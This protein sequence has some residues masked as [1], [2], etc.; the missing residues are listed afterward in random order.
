MGVSSCIV[1]GNKRSSPNKVSMHRFSKKQE[2]RMQWLGSLSLTQLDITENSRVCSIH[3]HDGNPCNI[4]SWSVGPK[5]ATQPDVD[6]ERS[7]RAQKRQRTF[8]ICTPATSKTLCSNTESDQP[9]PA[10]IAT[11][12]KSLAERRGSQ[13]L[14]FEENVSCIS[15][16]MRQITIIYIKYDLDVLP[17]PPRNV[18]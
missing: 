16:Y 18:C 17:P 4:P 5:F 1:C 14:D 13:N 8:K 12:D 2:V 10:L 9:P 11:L 7:K 15:I 6:S 3:F